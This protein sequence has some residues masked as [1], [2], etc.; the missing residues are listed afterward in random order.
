M[1]THNKEVLQCQNGEI[2]SRSCDKVAWL[3]ERNFYTFECVQ[4]LVGAIFTLASFYRQ[5][6]LDNKVQLKIQRQLR[7]A[8]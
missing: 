4:L 1:H 6:V 2:V 3:D 7:Q 5:R 8:V